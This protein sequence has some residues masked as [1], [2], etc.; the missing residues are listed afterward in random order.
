MKNYVCSSCFPCI[1]VIHNLLS[2]IFF[3]QLYYIIILTHIKLFYILNISE[4]FIVYILD[5]L[6]KKLRIF[7]TLGIIKPFLYKII[8]YLTVSLIKW[9]CNHKKSHLIYWGCII[10]SYSPGHTPLLS[11]ILSRAQS[12]LWGECWAG[13]SFLV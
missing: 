3:Y 4:L 1:N 13:W 5:P 9:E 6:K 8:Y 10:L 7:E 11:R 2:E 12:I